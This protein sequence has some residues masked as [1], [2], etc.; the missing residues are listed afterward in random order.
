MT[1][2]DL[3][4]ISRYVMPPLPLQPAK[5]GFLFGTRHGVEEF[6]REPTAL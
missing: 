1:A 3:L 6:C 2:D 4:S 5:L